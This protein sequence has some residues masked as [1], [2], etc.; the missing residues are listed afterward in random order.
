LPAHL[1]AS[2]RSRNSSV[3]ISPRAFDKRLRAGLT[4]DEIAQ[5][6][7]LLKRLEAGVAVDGG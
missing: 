4:D 2:R 7:D 3:E 6:R 1:R 5:L